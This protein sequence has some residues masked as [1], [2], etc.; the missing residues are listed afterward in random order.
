MPTWLTLLLASACGL[1]VANLYFA[2]PL[3]GPISADLGMNPQSA[4]LIVT[5]GQIGYGAGL[6]LVVPLADLVENR[7]LILALIGVVIAG[8]L[9]TA[10]STQAAPFLAATFLIGIS[11]VAVQILVPY[12]AHMAPDATRGRV[13]G[14]VMSGL[15]LGIMLSRPVA[16]FITE[17]FSWHAVFAISAAVMAALALVL[18]RTLPPRHPAPGLRY[19]ALLTSM[20][21]LARNTPVLQTRALYQACLF[22][23]FSLFWTT[24]PLVLANTFHLTQ[25]GIAL[26]AL[27]GIAGAISA[28]LAGRAADRGW[29]RTGTRA[30]MA[31]VAAS[32]L[33]AQTAT[34]GTPLGL[35]LLTASA[36][37][38]DFGITAN[39]VFGQ[40]AIF[41]LD[42]RIR[43]R[44]NGL[45]MASLFIGGAIASAL[46]AW[47]Y[48][49][50]GWPA[51][52]LVALALPLVALTATFM[53]ERK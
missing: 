14:N 23:A 51:T 2:Q 35:A 16:S 24:V 25:N 11:T 38:M 44:L 39:F 33:L 47:A 49:L 19:G 46:G 28:P 36:I 5:M 34:G 43:S 45:Y 17:A 9:A 18:W 20:I 41:A 31:L 1:I 48:A 3:I 15:M 40:R 4:G 13:V 50:G 52:M 37:L 26:F 12:A 27:A 32:F 29:S 21:V 42:A 6:L 10:L 22:G 53:E 7:R 8:L 30:A